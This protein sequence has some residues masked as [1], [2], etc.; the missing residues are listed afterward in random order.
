MIKPTA[1]NKRHK[2]HGEQ[3]AGTDLILPSKKNRIFANL[4]PSTTLQFSEVSASL[5]LLPKLIS[6]QLLELPDE[7]I[8]RIIRF[9]KIFGSGSEVCLVCK[10]LRNLS[11]DPLLRSLT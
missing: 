6:N 9:A 1:K 5:P 10:K 7:V 3:V 2:H 4:R 11:I 8:L